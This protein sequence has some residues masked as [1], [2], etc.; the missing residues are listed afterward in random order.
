MVQMVSS[1]FKQTH[2]GAQI[3]EC[4]TNESH[5]RLGEPTIPDWLPALYRHE[6]WIPGR[7]ITCHPPHSP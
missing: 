4:D 5:I 3:P 6:D 2:T 1:L 7:P